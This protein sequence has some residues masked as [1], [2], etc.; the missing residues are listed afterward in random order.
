MCYFEILL[1]LQCLVVIYLLFMYFNGSILRQKSGINEKN[2]KLG[3]MD[4][5]KQAKD[6]YIIKNDYEDIWNP[7]VGFSCEV[8]E[9]KV[10]SPKNSDTYNNNL[11]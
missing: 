11:E 5:K 9:I 4:A 8:I 1:I 7:G 6:E 10:E 3:L 2:Q